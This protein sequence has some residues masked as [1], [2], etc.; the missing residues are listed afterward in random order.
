VGF[1][2]RI[3]S[4]QAEAEPAAPIVKLPGDRILRYKITGKNPGTRR[5]NTRRVLCGSWEAISDVEARTGLLPPFTHELEMPEVTEAQLE[6]M[7]KL[8]VPML[9]GMYRVDASALIQH[10]LDEK[11]L[12]PDRGL[13][14]PI[15]QFLIDNE[16]LL[17]SWLTLSDLDDEFV[18]NF[19]GLRALIKNCK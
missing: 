1:F 8:G 17:S 19:P 10:A 13:P 4:R 2:S 6:L 5:R 11:P 16:L 3:F 7:K 9:D 14:R 12:F 15:L 18:E